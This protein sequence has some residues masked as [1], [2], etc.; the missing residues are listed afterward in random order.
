MWSDVPDNKYYFPCRATWK[1]I[2]PLCTSFVPSI[3]P[4]SS[5]NGGTNQNCAYFVHIGTPRSRW[6]TMVVV[7]EVVVE[8][9]ELMLAEN[10]LKIWIIAFELLYIGINYCGD[11]FLRSGRKL[12]LNTLI[13]M[14]IFFLVYWRQCFAKFS[15]YFWSIFREWLQ[16]Y[17]FAGFQNTAWSQNIMARKQWISM[18][19]LFNLNFQIIKK[20]FRTR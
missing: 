19:H 3:G 4:N 10:S 2:H 6:G 13:F 9:V 11:M 5:K 18:L 20:E 14:Q 12:W 15:F 16:K 1:A 8:V 7:V 17:D